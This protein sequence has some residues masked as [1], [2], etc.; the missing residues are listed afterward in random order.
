MRSGIFLT[1]GFDP[2]GRETRTMQPQCLA[3]KVILVTGAARRLG[4]AIARCMHGAGASVAIHH[5][6][7][8]Q[9][10]QRLRQE[11]DAARPGSAIALQA[12]LTAPGTAVTLVAETVAA[13]GRLDGL[14]NN[15]STF[16]ATPFGTITPQV[17]D[18]LIGTNLR[19][20]LFLA[21]AAASDLR[22]TQGMII[23]LVDIHAQRPLPDYAVYCVAK[24]GLAMLT[25]ALARE[26]GPEV[27]VNGI[28]PGPVLWPEGDLDAE[29]KSQ[30]VDRT[31]LKRSGTPE[32]V[33]RTAL[34]LAA[35]AP[36]VTGQILAVDGGRS[37]G[38]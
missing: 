16:Y 24:A 1:A 26:L 29:I 38:W 6:R 35:E 27:R 21:Q 13:F 15:A 22:R 34:F 33:A 23:N 32:D 17:F 25:R 3:G 18:D 4:A 20:P 19:A 28:A 11:L 8:A 14:V 5:F 10:A 30:I 31:A 12:D 36:Y 2:H 7:S 9:D 37:I